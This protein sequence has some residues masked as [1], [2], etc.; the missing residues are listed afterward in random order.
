MQLRRVWGILIIAAGV[1]SIVVGILVV[2][3]LGRLVALGAGLA[4]VKIGVVV[5]EQD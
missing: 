4:L 5:L 2:D 1:T 3:G